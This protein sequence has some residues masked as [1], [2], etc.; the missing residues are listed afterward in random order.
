MLQLPQWGALRKLGKQTG[1]LPSS[2]QLLQPPPKMH[3]RR[4]K[5]HRIRPQKAELHIKGMTATSPDPCVFP[6]T[7]WCLVPTLS[8]SAT[9]WSVALQAPLSMGFSR[10]G[11]G[12]IPFSRGSFRPQGLTPHLLLGGWILYH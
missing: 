10:Q 3:L 8:D 1:C 12:D 2:S 4:Q 6:H 5:Q 9:P 7:W 11:L